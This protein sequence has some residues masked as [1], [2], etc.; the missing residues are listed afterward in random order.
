MISRRSLLAFGAAL[1]ATAALA[2]DGP[3]GLDATQ[4]GVHPGSNDDQTKAL[5][6]AIDHAS[7]RRM[8]LWLAPGVYRAAALRL[9]A[10]S[11]LMGVRGATR[12]VLNKDAPLVT[13]TNAEN[14]SLN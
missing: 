7:E 5:Q 12:L 13:A 3:Q 2:Y 8:P 4:L 1:S 9:P 11:Q 10:G 14:V 6:R